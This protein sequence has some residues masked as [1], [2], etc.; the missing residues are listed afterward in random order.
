M[1]KFA[2]YYRCVVDVGVTRHYFIVFGRGLSWF[3]VLILCYL[4]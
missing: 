3:M 2:D 4:V 1:I